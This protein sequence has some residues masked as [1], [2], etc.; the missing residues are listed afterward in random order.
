M[1]T[2]RQAH[3]TA[4]D[5]VADRDGDGSRLPPNTS[6]GVHVLHSDRRTGSLVISIVMRFAHGI[7]DTARMFCT[8]RRRGSVETRRGAWGLGLAWAALAHN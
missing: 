6:A 1:S 2:P 3:A 7:G 4:R 8:A 5:A